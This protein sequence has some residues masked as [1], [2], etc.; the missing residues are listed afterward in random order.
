MHVHHI[1]TKRHDRPELKDV[2]V[3][4]HQ[5]ILLDGPGD[6]L[7]RLVGLALIVVILHVLQGGKGRLDRDV[8]TLVAGIGNG[9]ADGG[10]EDVG[11]SILK[12]QSVSGF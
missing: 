5:H 8:V 6:S 2:L 7:E 12:C 1:D 11:F 4:R 3:E 9:A 10:A